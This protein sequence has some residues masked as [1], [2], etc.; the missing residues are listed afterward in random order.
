MKKLK[1]I[2]VG[3]GSR[4]ATYSTVMSK[5]KEKFQIVAVAEPRKDR[6]DY[7]KDLYNLENNMCFESYEPL[8][9]LGKIADFAVIATMDKDHLKP[10]LKA[11]ELGYD[12]LLEKPIAPTPEEC[13]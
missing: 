5:D 3:A 9:R 6:R 10:A 2:V 12:L 8:F 7:I 13:I 4:G 1:A 11:I